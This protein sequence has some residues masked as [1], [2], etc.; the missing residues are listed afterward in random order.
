M[1]P[2]IRPTTYVIDDDK[3]VRE[4]LRW[5]IESVG[6]PVQT[7][8]SARE[9]LSSFKNNHPGC[10]IIDVRMPEMS[11]LELQEHLNAK[12]VQMPVIIITGHGDVPMAVRALKAGAMDFIEKPF[13]DQALLDRIQHALQ[14]HLETAQQRAELDEA[15]RAYAQLTRR[16][17]EVL[18]RVV[19]GETS[20]RIAVELGLSTKTIEAH[21]AKIMHKLHVKSLAELVRVSVA[22][23]EHS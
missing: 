8:G 16:E 11:G 5:L 3:A 21:R 14:R 17:Q 19:S 4:S 22:C 2:V 13:N 23:T 18:Q 20:K 7:Y 6:L 10:I 12:R 9:F 1:N 15:R